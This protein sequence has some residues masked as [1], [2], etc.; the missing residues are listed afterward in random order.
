MSMLIRIPDQYKEI[1]SNT[2]EIYLKLYGGD[3]IF[4]RI[5]SI[6]IPDKFKINSS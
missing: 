5:N 2:K 1:M 4:A 3:W 6:E